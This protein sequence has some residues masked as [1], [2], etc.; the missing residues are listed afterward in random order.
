VIP[1]DIPCGVV[2]RAGAVASVAALRRP[3]VRSTAQRT[4]PRPLPCG[5]AR[6]RTTGSTPKDRSTFRVASLS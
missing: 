4:F 2:A 1:A 5:V 3:N 6:S